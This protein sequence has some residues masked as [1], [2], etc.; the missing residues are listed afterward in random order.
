MIKTAFFICTSSVLFAALPPLAQ[1]TK[2]MRAILN[3][4]QLYQALGSAQ[5]IEEMS[6]IDNGW[7]V[8]TQE[9]ALQV[10]VV[11]LEQKRAGPV[12]FELRFH[13][14]MDVNQW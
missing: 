4:S 12:Q 10:D 8:K 14:P 2:E 11:Y 1:S 3:D 7:V 6:R 13:Q 5:N 9:Y